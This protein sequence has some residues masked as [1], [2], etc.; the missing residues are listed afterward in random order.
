MVDRHISPGEGFQLASFQPDGDERIAFPVTRVQWKGEL[1]HHVHEFLHAAGGKLEDQERRIYEVRFDAIFY[2]SFHGK[3]YPKLYPNKL[4]TLVRAFETGKHGTLVVPSPI[5][6][7]IPAKCVNWEG[8]YESRILSGETVNLVFKED[9]DDDFLITALVDLSPA[10]L[11]EQAKR[12]Q[13]EAA[14]LSPKPS[15]FDTINDA[16][17]AVLRVR[18]QADL[19]GMYLVS[20]LEYIADL[21]STA[22][23]LATCKDPVRAQLSDALH[24]VWAAAKDAANDILSK[25][26]PLQK[27]RVPLTTSLVNVAAAIYRGDGS[28][29]PELQ[30][31]NPDITDPFVVRAGTVLRFYPER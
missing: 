3:G 6:G 2:D 30:I 26:T 11:P 10:A 24:D 22:D 15:I 16:V 17:N 14:K 12:L 18:D 29:G 21:C 4:D 31:L 20:K 5:I 13:V 9:R 1:R 28:R 25:R 7:A 23:D 8:T 27:Y 19:Y